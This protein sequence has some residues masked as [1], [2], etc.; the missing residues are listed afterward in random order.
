[1]ETA[2]TVT[3]KDFFLWL[4]I[5][6]GLYGSVIALLAL[7]FEYINRTFPD[8]LAGYA[9]PYATAVHVS[10]ATLIVLV[11]LTAVLLY[12]VRS[13]IEKNPEKENIWVRRWAIVLTLFIAGVVVAIDLIT[14]FTTFLGGEV[15]VRFAL[16][17]LAVL[18]IGI[19]VFL[20]FLA[21][22]WGYWLKNA[23]KAYAVAIAAII[24]NVLVIV[25]GFVVVGTPQDM[26]LQRIDAQ[27]V[28]DLQS[29]QWKIVV[30][31]QQH[32]TL[33]A[34]LTSFNDPI[35]GFVLPVDPQ[36]REAYNYTVTAPDSFK[37]CA[38]FSRDSLELAGMGEY[39]ARDMSYPSKGSIDNW[40]H[41]I[42][43]TCFDS[44]IDP[45]L[46]PPYPKP[47]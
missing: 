9:D 19:W 3:P 10:M 36:T 35:S 23:K 44:T 39:G 7:L 4:G 31:Y 20:H 25:A 18:L 21:E 17:V 13:S 5:I 42:G 43:E 37:L 11:P 12:L 38:T 16:K 28:E 33:A 2:R 14:L 29:L 41:G 24:L 46:Y 40:R 6:I 32:Q 27:R 22:R 26:R 30:H 8:V 1:M 15:T 45:E 34:D 47:L